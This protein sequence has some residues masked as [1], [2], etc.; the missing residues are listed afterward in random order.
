MCVRLTL[1]CVLFDD[2]R[3]HSL[4]LMCSVCLWSL[5]I[6]FHLKKI[7]AILLIDGLLN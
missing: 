7:K 1:L 5:L 2:K 4:L 3:L 6:Y